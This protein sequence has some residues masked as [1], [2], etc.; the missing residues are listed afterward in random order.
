MDISLQSQ[1]QQSLNRNRYHWTI[2]RATKLRIDYVSGQFTKILL[3]PFHEGIRTRNK[4]F[5]GFKSRCAIRWEWQYII[6]SNKILHVSR[7]SFSL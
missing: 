2:K 5:S 7:A 3:Q 4:R 6:A 1:N